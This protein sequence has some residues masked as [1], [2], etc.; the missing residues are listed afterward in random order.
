MEPTV[1]EI[2][3][4]FTWPH[5]I[6]GRSAL[7]DLDFESDVSSIQLYRTSLGAWTRVK[8]GHIIPVEENDR[9]FLKAP[10]SPSA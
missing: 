7:N 4:G 6:I 8:E 10:K 2:Q 5:F 9:V 1:V 3:D